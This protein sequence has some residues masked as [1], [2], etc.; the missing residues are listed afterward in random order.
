M[1]ALAKL[2]DAAALVAAAKDESPSVRLA[3]ALALR[4]LQSPKVA[5]FLNDADRSVVLEAARAINDLPI[6]AALPQLAALLDKHD[7]R[8]R[9]ARLLGKG[10]RRQRPQ[11]HRRPSLMG[12]V[13]AVN[14][15]Y[16]LGTAEAAKRLAAFAARN[17]APDAIR[18]EA[19]KD[20]GNWEK[21]SGRDRVTNLW[22]PLPPRDAAVANAPRP[23]GRRRNRQER[24]RQG[25]HRRDQRCTTGHRRPRQ[26]GGDGREH[27][28]RPQGPRR[29]PGL[30]GRRAKT[31]RTRWPT[32]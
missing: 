13:A 16:R 32:R 5:E 3:A 20:L 19:L 9:P 15:N 1:D 23:A 21:P 29:R 10:L 31:A 14:A 17:D 26:P 2:G 11:G 30:A 28:A 27:Q 8:Q 24:P 7:G 4:R 6:E 18:V 22:R 12:P 25:P